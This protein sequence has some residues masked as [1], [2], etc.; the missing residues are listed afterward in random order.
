[1]DSLPSIP[2]LSAGTAD[3]LARDFVIAPHNAWRVIEARGERL[4][5]YL[6]GQI[7][8]DIRRLSREQAIHAALLTPQGKPVSELYLLDG[9]APDAAEQRIWLIAPAS[10]AEAVVARLQRFSLGFSVRFGESGLALFSAQ[11]AAAAD[12]PERLGIAEPGDGW[13][14]VGRAGDAMLPAA[15]VMPAAPRGFWLAGEAQCIRE[16]LAGACWIEPE[17]LE[18]MRIIRGLPRFGVEW[19]ESIHPL[20][21][22]LIEMDGVAFDKGCY[23]GQEVTSRMRWRGGIRK[24]LWRV[25]LEAAAEDEPEPPLP[26][27][28]AGGARIGELRSLARDHEGRLF[29]IALLPVEPGCDALHTPEGATA[30]LI[31]PVHV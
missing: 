8:Q 10:R 23:V 25:G 6:Q 17:E 28:A 31:E 21:A 14:A 15:I 29:G 11:G 27:L 20:N 9:S 26:L 22:N 24:R 4:R 7:T 3:R 2:A 5:D 1:M 30:R 12:A 13:L 16:A 19:D 18:A